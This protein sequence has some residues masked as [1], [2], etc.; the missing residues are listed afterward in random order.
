MQ[1]RLWTL[2]V[3]VVLAT[4]AA[5]AHA[6]P[7][8][9]FDCITNSDATQCAIGEAQLS[10]EVL[11]AGGG[12]VAFRFENAGA[13]PATITQIYF[14]DGT[15][16]SI[17]SITDSGLGVAFTEGAN[18]G[19]LPGGETLIPAFVADFSAGADP[20]P[21]DNGVD[22]TEWVSILFD[23]QAGGTYDG[24]ISGLANGDLRIGLHVQSIGSGSELG[25]SESFVNNPGTPIPEPGTLLLLGA[26]LTGL[27]SWRRR[28]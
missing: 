27:A 21:A 4:F 24:V 19:N 17:A 26:G 10:V 22:P 8:Y 12:Q 5:P 2:G 13:D 1:K 6:G 16:L 14:D 25:G 18:P 11:D 7:I 9:S 15:L 28:R 3:G 23:L 20:P